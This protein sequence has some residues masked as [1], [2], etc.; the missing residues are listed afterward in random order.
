MQK[1]IDDAYVEIGA[2]I[3]KLEFKDATEKA[4]RLIEEANKYYD[5]YINRSN[6]P[7]GTAILAD[8]DRKMYMPMPAIKQKMAVR[9]PV[10]NIAQQHSKQVTI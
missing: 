9:V 1:L 6:N 2:A 4:I 8:L 5:D 10:A 7:T 3:E